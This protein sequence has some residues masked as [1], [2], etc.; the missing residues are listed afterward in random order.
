MLEFKKLSYFNFIQMYLF[1]KRNKNDIHFF[2]PHEFNIKSL[3][4]N[5]HNKKDFFICMVYKKKIIGYGML[6]GWK[7]GFDTP[8]L[9][10]MINKENRGFGLSKVMMEFLHVVCKFRNCDKVML[11]VT[12]D[13]IKAIN[14]YKKLGYNLND[15][16]EK[17][18]IGYKKIKDE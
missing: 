3:L 6:R 15:Y 17:F 9:G 16:N 8:S 18:L 7:E 1:L 4:K 11:K 13:N 2:K 5:I 12:K 14:L 10:I